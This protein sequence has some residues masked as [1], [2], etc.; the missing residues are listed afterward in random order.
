MVITSV[1]R[2]V[3][4]KSTTL[5]PVESHVYNSTSTFKLTLASIEK[6]VI[7][8]HSPEGKLVTPGSFESVAYVPI[9]VLVLP[10][11]LVTTVC[12][13]PPVAVP[14]HCLYV[15]VPIA[16]LVFTDWFR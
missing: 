7:Q 11:T 9:N 10:A 14:D 16:V 8:D 1:S 2:L 3:V 5:P 6:C 4:P 13:G 15:G 12:C